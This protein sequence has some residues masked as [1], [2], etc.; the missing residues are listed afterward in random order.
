[1]AK[2]DYTRFS[3]N[4]E[5]DRF[6]E[7]AGSFSKGVEEGIKNVLEEEV[8]ETPVVEAVSVTP[9]VGVVDGCDNLNVREKASTTSSVVCVL[10][11]GSEVE[12]YENESDGDFYRICTSVGL[13]GFCMKP[14][15][16]LK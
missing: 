12:V 8:A 14:F 7:V 16:K 9:K 10:K 6:E 5:K 15:V 11:K 2:K 4:R 3:N 1:M 13:E